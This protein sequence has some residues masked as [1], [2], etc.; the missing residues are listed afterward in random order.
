METVPAQNVVQPQA[1]QP[2][3]VAAQPTPPP[4]EP[5]VPQPPVPPVPSEKGSNNMM[6]IALIIVILCMMVGAGAYLFFMNS[7]Q[8]AKNTGYMIKK[9][10]LTE[11]TSA[12]P[13]ATMV[14]AAE[15]L[16]PIQSGDPQLDGDFS[17]IDRNMSKIQSDESG[18]SEGLSQKEA[19]LSE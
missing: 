12:S 1:V 9:P 14:E 17:A 13:T 19:Y 7:S 18:V 3:P 4:A 10:N 15:T 11:T 2:Q 6:V 16:A 8:K 5:I